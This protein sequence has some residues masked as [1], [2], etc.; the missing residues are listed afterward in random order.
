MYNTDLSSLGVKLGRGASRAQQEEGSTSVVEDNP[1]TD[2]S[3]G[4]VSLF[5]H[6]VGFLHS[7]TYSE[8]NS[9]DMIYSSISYDGIVP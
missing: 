6:G 1:G 7:F 4:S 5:P 9:Y 3:S 2:N 8:D